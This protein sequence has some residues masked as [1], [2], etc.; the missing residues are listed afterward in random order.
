MSY[1]HPEIWEIPDSE[2]WKIIMSG[3][4]HRWNY[5]NRTYW[6]ERDRLEGR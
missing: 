3:K 1:T 5:N 4:S 6:D 2:W